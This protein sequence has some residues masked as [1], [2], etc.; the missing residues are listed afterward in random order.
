MSGY[1]TIQ[2]SN[3]GLKSDIKS[4]F[5]V[6]IVWYLNGGASHVTQTFEYGMHTASGIQ[7]SSIQMVFVC[8]PCS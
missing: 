3:G 1:Q 6:Q 4:L 7:M 2:L 8:V 5:M